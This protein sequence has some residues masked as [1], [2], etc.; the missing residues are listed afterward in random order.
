MSYNNLNEFSVTVGEK[1]YH[2][3]GHKDPLNNQL[4]CEIDGK[5]T[6]SRVVMQDAAIHVFTNV[7]VAHTL[8]IPYCS[9]LQSC[10]TNEK[11]YFK[12]MIKCKINTKYKILMISFE[13]LNYYSVLSYENKD[14]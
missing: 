14:I 7:S 1:T 9:Y 12:S 2:V 8:Y 10:K 13:C 3:T 11:S 5:A 4:M 6:K